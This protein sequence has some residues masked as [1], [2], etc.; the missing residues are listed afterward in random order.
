M[1]HVLIYIDLL[2]CG[3]VDQFHDV[4][5]EPWAESQ[6]IIHVSRHPR[7]LACI[8]PT[9][10]FMSKSPSLTESQFTVWTDHVVH[11]EKA[12]SL[13]SLIVDNR[14]P[15]TP[16]LHHIPLVPG[17]WQ[18]I[19]ES[20]DPIRYTI[21]HQ[22]TRVN[23]PAVIFSA[24]YCFRYMAQYSPGLGGL[25]SSAAENASTQVHFDPS[26]CTWSS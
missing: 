13:T 2:P 6:N 22:V 10:T 25:E 23:D 17:Y 19:V 20:P 24:S 1:P 11:T 9:V 21:L 14:F 3:V 26:P 7:R 4:P 18:T 5:S 12:V 15:D 8:D 16:F